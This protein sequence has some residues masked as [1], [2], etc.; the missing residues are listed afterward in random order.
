MT[1]LN[2]VISTDVTKIG[3]S[4]IFNLSFV[5]VPE[6]EWSSSILLQILKYMDK[7]QKINEKEIFLQQEFLPINRT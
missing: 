6:G 7:R 4:L 5:N 3:F 2:I 1:R